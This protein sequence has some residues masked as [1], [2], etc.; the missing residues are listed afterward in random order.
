MLGWVG[1]AGPHFDLAWLFYWKPSTK[2]IPEAQQ[3][4]SSLEFWTWAFFTAQEQDKS[5]G[6]RQG[7]ETALCEAMVR[8]VSPTGQAQ[9]VA[10]ILSH[11]LEAPWEPGAAEKLGDHTAMG[12]PTWERPC[13]EGP[14]YQSGPTAQLSPWGSFHPCTSPSELC[15]RKET[16]RQHI[17]IPA[18]PS[19]SKFQETL[20]T[21]QAVVLPVAVH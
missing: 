16:F 10:D 18:A 21:P 15:S 17:F 6:G 5:P 7:T 14:C 13:W 19:R 1:L 2:K 11:G 3:L 12:S 9:W 8:L 20:S 4:P